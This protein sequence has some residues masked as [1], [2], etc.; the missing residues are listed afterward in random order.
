LALAIWLWLGPLGPLKMHSMIHLHVLF[1]ASWSV[2]TTVV[3]FSTCCFPLICFRWTTDICCMYCCSLESFLETISSTLWS[4]LERTTNIFTI[5]SHL[6]Y[7]LSFSSSKSIHNQTLWKCYQFHLPLQHIYQSPYNVWTIA[8]TIL[9]K[10]FQERIA[11]SGV[12][13]KSHTLPAVFPLVILQFAIFPLFWH[14]L[15]LN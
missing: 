8:N 3:S 14:C 9:W 10:P 1:Y 6:F 7:F 5:G 11:A 2:H 4:T 12:A 13:P 15:T